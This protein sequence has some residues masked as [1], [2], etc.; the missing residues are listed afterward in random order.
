MKQTNIQNY[1]TII[2]R[3]K[4]KINKISRVKKI[5]E[6]FLKKSFF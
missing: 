6:L 3:R 5:L 4:L 2:L 1:K